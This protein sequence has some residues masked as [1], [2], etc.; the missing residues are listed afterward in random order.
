MPS[1]SPEQR[2]T[3]RAA[4]KDPAFAKKVGIPQDVAEDFFTADQH[5]AAIAQE[6]KRR[7]KARTP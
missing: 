3:M 6:L 5:R 7:A 1:T 4:A 2:K